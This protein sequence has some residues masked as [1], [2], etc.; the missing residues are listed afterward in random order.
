MRG[1]NSTSLQ[2]RDDLMTMLIAGHETS[3]AVLT[4][5]L[6]ELVRHPAALAKVGREEG[7]KRGREGGREGGR[8]GEREGGREGGSRKE[9]G[10]SSRV[11]I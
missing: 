7:R 6:F 9:G 4:W 8:K 5:T 1:E 3:A 10:Y 11:W 2:L